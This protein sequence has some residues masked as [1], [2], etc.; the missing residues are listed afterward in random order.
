MSERITLGFPEPDPAGVEGDIG[1]AIFSS[2]CIHGRPQTRLDVAYW[3][4]LDGEKAV[5]EVRGP[6]GESALR[7]LLGLLAA[8]FGETGFTVRRASLDGE[9]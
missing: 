5:V 3:L 7:V 1:L 9:E 4:P 2:E 8:R 6:A